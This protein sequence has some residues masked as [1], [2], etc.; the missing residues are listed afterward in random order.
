MI[1][2]DKRSRLAEAADKL[3][4]EQGF[5]RTTLAEIAEESRVPLGNVYYY[6]KTKEALGEALIQR[7]ADHYRALRETWDANPDPKARL[8]GFVQMTMDNSAQLAEFGCPIGSLC[9]ELHKQGGRLAGQAGQMFSEFLEWLEAQ[10]RALGKGKESPSLALHLLSATEGAT[11]LT[12]SFRDPKYVV[13][14]AKGLER[15]I[16]AL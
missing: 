2:S 5:S 15:W 8:C 3:V 12:N 4:Y 11:L 13:Q 1:R 6:F 10:F 7:R 16:R 14:E 9:Q